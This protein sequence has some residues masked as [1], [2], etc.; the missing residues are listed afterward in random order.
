MSVPS[1]PFSDESAKLYEQYVAHNYATAAITLVR[2]EGTKVWDSQGKC[3]LDFASG[4]AVNALGHSHPTWVKRVTEQAS[5]LIH[6]SNLYRNEPQARLAQKLSRYC[7]PG[8]ALFCNS[9]AEA[10]EAL[11]KLA[12]LHG[13]KKSGQEGLCIGVVVAERAFH[14]RTFGGMSAT[15][16]EKIQH[17]FRPLLS[18]F[19]AAPLNDIAAWDRAINP[20]TTAAVLIETIQGEGGIF[21]A[22]P[23]FLQKVQELCRERNVLFLI[24]EIQCGIG[25]TGKF[26]AYEYA[27]VKPDAIAMAKGLGSGFPIGAI[28]MSPRCDELFQP[29]SHGTTFGGSPLAASAALAVLEV[30]ESE[31]LIERVARQSGAWHSALKELAKKYPE[32]IKEIRGVGY[33]VGVAVQVDPLPLVAA[34][35]EAGLLAVPASGIAIRL[36]PPLN[37]SVAELNESVAIFDRVLS[38]RKQA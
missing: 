20:Q 23:E 34:L 10:N 33:M 29:G 25:R 12:R 1:T 7:G 11:L 37:A 16:Q 5:R 14:G 4:I 38:Q 22:K 13:K 9:G 24:D 2:G 6:V 28:W 15:P 17:G 8:R 32:V 19:T 27:G 26:F 3:Y 31:A 35:R 30:L 21:E 18:G 36:L